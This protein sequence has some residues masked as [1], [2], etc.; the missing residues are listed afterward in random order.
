MLS[1]TFFLRKFNVPLRDQDDASSIQNPVL[2]GN[3]FWYNGAMCFKQAFA[4]GLALADLYLQM[5][6]HMFGWCLTWLGKVGNEGQV[7]MCR[8]SLA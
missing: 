2:Q 6:L 4:V 5:L 8:R 1:S 3:L 7:W